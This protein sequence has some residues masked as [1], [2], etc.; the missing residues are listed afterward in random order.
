MAR[1]A[2]HQRLA[3]GEDALWWAAMSDVTPAAVA[4]TTASRERGLY[5]AYLGVVPAA[6]G[7]GLAGQVV[8][9]LIDRLATSGMPVFGD[10]SR[11]NVA[12]MRV[13]GRCA[14]PETRRYDIYA[15]KALPAS[16]EHELPRGCGWSGADSRSAYDDACSRRPTGSDR[17]I[18]SGLGVGQ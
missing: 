16:L 3:C 9:R 4:L 12:I 2:E 10:V 13:M 14:M 15:T 1:A 11:H 7:R 17:A 5:L 18:S 8:S 6:R